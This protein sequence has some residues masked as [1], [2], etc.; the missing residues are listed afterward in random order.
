MLVGFVVSE[1]E[2]AAIEVT[3]QGSD[4]EI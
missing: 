3:D 1:R 2:M 4:L